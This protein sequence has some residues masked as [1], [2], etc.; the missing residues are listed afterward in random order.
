MV[1]IEYFYTNEPISQSNELEYL[2]ISLD[3]GNGI[4]SLL[5]M[6]DA[7]YDFPTEKEKFLDSIENNIE[8]DLYLDSELQ[9]CIKYTGCDSNDDIPKFIIDT[10]NRTLS[11]FSIELQLD[12]KEVI[13]DIIDTVSKYYDD[14]ASKIISNNNDPYDDYD[15]VY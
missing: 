7:N 2:N 1:K 8:Y 13:M 4:K 9:L 11:S 6:I 3:F 12:Y 14:N 15:N 10:Y 5:K